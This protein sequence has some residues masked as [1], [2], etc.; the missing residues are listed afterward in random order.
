MKEVINR[1]VGVALVIAAIAGLI[2]NIAGAV[3]VWRQKEPVTVSLVSTATS[4]NNAL[5]T[6]VRALDVAQ[7][8]LQTS[9]ESVIAVEKTITSTSKTIQSSSP[10][11]D[12]LAELMKTDLPRTVST[13][14]TSLDSAQESARLIDSFLRALANIPFVPDNLYNPPVPLHT[15]L[16]NVSASLNDLPQAFTSMGN[17]LESAGGNLDTVQTD[18]ALIATNIATI[19]TSLENAQE[20]IREYQVTVSSLQTEMNDTA[21]RIPG[22]IDAAAWVLTFVFAW[23]GL[24][25]FGLLF[26]GMEMLGYRLNDDD[27]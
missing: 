8:S 13:A 27:D 18:V 22:F 20:V 24:A 26:Q 10:M 6:T 17:S 23:L 14:R 3:F 11:V 2:F 4:I 19:N 1:I 16:G 9:L 5:G 12:T 7:Q 15:A 21:A 25:Q